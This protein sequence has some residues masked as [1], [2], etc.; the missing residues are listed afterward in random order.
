MILN[1]ISEQWTPAQHAQKA[2]DSIRANPDSFNMDFWVN[3]NQPHTRSV[4]LEPD[5]DLCGTTMCVAGW[6]AHNAGYPL[7]LS[8]YTDDE[9]H[10]KDI[11]AQ[12]L[13]LDWAQSTQLFN[14]NESTAIKVLERL[15]TGIVW[16][17][18][19][20]IAD[21]AQVEMTQEN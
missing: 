4:Y 7:D 2:L 10:A 15:A 21:Y 9:V 11:A 13:E 6:V 14:T 8:G 3:W 19:E 20:E 12:A 16:H 1:A 17:T 18:G 5:G